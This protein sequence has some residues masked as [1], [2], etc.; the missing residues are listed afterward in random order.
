MRSREEAYRLLGA[1]SFSGF[2]RSKEKRSGCFFDALFSV[3]RECPASV[4][5]YACGAYGAD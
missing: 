1:Q 3:E 5:V 4:F 2:E